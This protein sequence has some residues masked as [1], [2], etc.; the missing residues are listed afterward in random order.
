MWFTVLTTYRGELA[1]NVD[2]ITKKQANHNQIGKKQ[3]IFPKYL[4]K[5][6]WPHKTGD[7]STLVKVVQ[8]I[9]VEQLFQVV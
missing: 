3:E 9:Y 1:F 5:Q 4:F 7:F 2:N 8:M 6:T